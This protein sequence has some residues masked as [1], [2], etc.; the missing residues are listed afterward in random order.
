MGKFTDEVVLV[1]GSSR[2]IGKAIAK[3]FAKEGATTVIN[4]VQNEAAA[5]ETVEEIEAA[6]G[7]AWAIKADVSDRNDVI[8]MIEEIELEAGKIDTVVN[9]AFK[10]Y[11]FDPENRKFAWE[12]TWEDYQEQIDGSLKSVCL[13]TEAVLPLMKSRQKGSIINIVTNLVANPI[14][15][16]HEYTTAK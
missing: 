8:Q 15:A 13:M 11:K 6:G 12:V 2:G 16:Y 4:Y 5:K 3:A 10:P 7:D 9:N 1:T 14:V